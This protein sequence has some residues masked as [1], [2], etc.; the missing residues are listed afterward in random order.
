MPIDSDAAHYSRDGDGLHY[1]YGAYTGPWEAVGGI[2]ATDVRQAR[3]RIG[4]KVA[5]LVA[6]RSRGQ[7]RIRAWWGNVAEAGP[8]DFH[9]LLEGVADTED[10]RRELLAAIHSVRFE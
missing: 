9:L 4:G 3:A 2:D 6:Y 8:L 5:E 7:Y 10:D 1:D